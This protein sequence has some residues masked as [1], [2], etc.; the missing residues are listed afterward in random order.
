V[1]GAIS[2][3]LAAVDG[4]APVGDAIALMIMATEIEALRE[5]VKN[6]QGAIE[7]IRSEINEMLECEE[8]GKKKDG[9]N[10][11]GKKDK[12]KPLEGTGRT[13]GGGYGGGKHGALTKGETGTGLE[14][15]HMPAQGNYTVRPTN[16]G[17]NEP[18]ILMDNTDHYKT[19]SHGGGP[20]T[21]VYNGIQKVLIKNNLTIV[22]MAM[23][24]ANV[25]WI[26]DPPGKYD[27]AITEM[28][29]W[30]ICAG[31]I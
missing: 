17:A 12:C 3:V 1:K 21:K 24:I 18:A 10:V 22:A 27:D 11:K 26:A 16:S 8:V 6:I 5:D 23:D 7:D 15:H 29:L 20:I 25:K 30:S 9:E 2:A 14:S 31:K 19:L 28:L 4:P 13:K